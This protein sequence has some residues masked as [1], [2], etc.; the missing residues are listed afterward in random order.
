MLQAAFVRMVGQRRQQVQQ[1]THLW[2]GER[3]APPKKI[4][5]GDT[6]DILLDQKTTVAKV[7]SE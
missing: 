7:S 3:T 2:R 5:Q 4:Q 6:D 1:P